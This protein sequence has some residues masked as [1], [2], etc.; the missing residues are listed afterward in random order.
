MRNQPSSGF[1]QLIFCKELLDV[2]SAEQ[3]LCWRAPV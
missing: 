1:I 2:V 3:C